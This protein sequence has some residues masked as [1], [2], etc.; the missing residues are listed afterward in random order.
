MTSVLHDHVGG[1]H[2][3]PPAVE[4]I[5]ITKRFGQ[6]VA[7]DRVSITLHRGRIHGILGEN[8]AGKSTLM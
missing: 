6:I 2:S 3:S 1:E 8:G 5:D 7:C 4:L